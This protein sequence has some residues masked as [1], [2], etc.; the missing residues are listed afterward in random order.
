MSILLLGQNLILSYKSFLSQ[1]M[2]S[3]FTPLPPTTFHQ[4]YLSTKPN[5]PTTDFCPPG[6]PFTYFHLGAILLFGTKP[7]FHPKSLI[8][9]KKKKKTTSLVW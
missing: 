7:Y 4:L 2:S 5:P 6:L 8:I 9:Q 3:S 1:K